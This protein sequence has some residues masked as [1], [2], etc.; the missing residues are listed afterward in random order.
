[1][2]TSN[3]TIT[4]K[5]G[6]SDRIVIPVFDQD[7]NE[8]DITSYEATIELKKRASSDPSLAIDNP[9]ITK[10]YGGENHKLAFLLSAVQTAAL[11]PWTYMVQVTLNSTFVS[12][13]INS[14]MLWLTIEQ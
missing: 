6:E 12:K 9:D 11:D 8:L 4:L 5:Q 13:N 7:D 1:M 2:S 14:Q 10:G 3:T